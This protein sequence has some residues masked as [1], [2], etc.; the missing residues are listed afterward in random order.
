VDQPA[1][2]FLQRGGETWM[3]MTEA[4]DGHAGEGVEILLPFGVPQPHAFAPFEN[5]GQARISV[6][7]VRHGWLGVKSGMADAR[8]QNNT[9]AVAAAV[10]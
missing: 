6:H 1:D 5:H 10:V 3:G 8:S 2:L 4:V 9:A 7:Q